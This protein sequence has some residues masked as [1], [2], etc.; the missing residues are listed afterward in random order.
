MKQHNKSS[1]IILSEMK[2]HQSF[3]EKID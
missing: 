3:F 1:L 2:L